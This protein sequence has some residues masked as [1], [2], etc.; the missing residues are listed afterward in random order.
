[1]KDFIKIVIQAVLIT[2]VI[3]GS[4]IG[5]FCYADYRLSSPIEIGK[6]YEFIL[7]SDD[8][9]KEVRV[10]TILIQDKMKGYVKFVLLK[11]DIVLFEMSEKESVLNKCINPIK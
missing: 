6:R 3:I 4:V 7:E 5:G 8:P 9:F 10:D 2:L 11:N 1:M